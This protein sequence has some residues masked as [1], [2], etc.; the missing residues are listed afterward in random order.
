[1]LFVS[2]VSASHK[3]VLVGRGAARTI[4]RSR[5]GRAFGAVASSLLR[6]GH[7]LWLEVTGFFFAVFAVIGGAALAREVQVHATAGRIAVLA[8]FTLMFAWFAVS[9]FIRARKRKKQ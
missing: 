6:V 3:A 8:I 2:E 5:W 7:V 4:V 9:S 1:M